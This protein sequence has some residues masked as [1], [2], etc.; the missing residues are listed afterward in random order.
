MLSPIP[1]V[2]LTKVNLRMTYLMVMGNMSGMTIL[3]TKVVLL[4]D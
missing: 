3:P 4:M 2:T 1:M